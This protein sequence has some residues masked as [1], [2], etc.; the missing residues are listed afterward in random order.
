MDLQP[1]SLQ[2]AHSGFKSN[3]GIINQQPEY[4]AILS[5]DDESKFQP[6]SPKISP[7]KVQ[8]HNLYSQPEVV[9]PPAS[10]YQYYNYNVKPN[11]RTQ[12]TQ[13]SALIDNYSYFNLGN[14]GTTTPGIEYASSNQD[15]AT[16]IPPVPNRKQTQYYN[17]FQPV[18]NAPSQTEYVNIQRPVLDYEKRRPPS[19]K[20]RNTPRV[21]INNSKK[22]QQHHAPLYRE[23]Q[24]QSNY[25]QEPVNTESIEDNE[26]NVEENNS[27]IKSVFPSPPSFFY[28]T[29]NKYDNIE[30]PFANPDFDFDTFISKLQ[31]NQESQPKQVIPDT[32]YQTYSTQTKRPTT[33]QT[34]NSSNFDLR[35]PAPFSILVNK[36]PVNTRPLEEDYYYDD[37]EENINEDTNKSNN[38][39]PITN[40]EYNIKPVIS[41]PSLTG[42]INR[43]QMHKTNLLQ[44]KSVTAPRIKTNAG[45]QSSSSNENERRQKPI[46]NNQYEDKKQIQDDY[47]YY[48]DYDYPDS[49]DNIDNK[50]ILPKRPQPP[51]TKTSA[52]P[53]A[54][55]ESYANT[56]KPISNK[57]PVPPNRAATYE[58]VIYQNEHTPKVTKTT[59]VRTTSS[60]VVPQ[61]HSS[62]SKPRVTTH[63]S[64]VTVTTTPKT[65][66]RSRQPQRLPTTTLRPNRK[67]DTTD[68]RNKY[69]KTR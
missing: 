21:P 55:S 64:R 48:D 63:V 12:F 18:T 37:D 66:V 57:K 56:R 50:Q 45:V 49:A 36:K 28:K 19:H 42:Q 11:S 52:I 6:F 9:Q 10:N 39:H 31:I 30:N 22:Q 61:R 46:K 43:Q 17:E 54:S 23:D 41:N 16:Q 51:T 33:V 32:N 13:N 3:A 29:S 26:R 24:V 40:E 27:E 69:S 5:Q 8:V 65:T 35:T 68:T 2:R 14:V 60:Y 59:P 1:Y 67:P 53:N 47:E 7:Y 20:Q 25:K 15:R 58:T 34:I 4:S 62:T 38:K 44:I